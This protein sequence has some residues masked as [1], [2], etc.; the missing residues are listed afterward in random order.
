[1]PEHFVG[2]HAYFLCVGVVLQT[3]GSGVTG[4]KLTLYDT[5]DLRNH[6][7]CVASL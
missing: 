4:E 7:A 6:P 2:G 1:M 3:I 5:L